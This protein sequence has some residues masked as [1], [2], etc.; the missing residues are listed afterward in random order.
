MPLR[1][2]SICAHPDDE[3]FAFGGALALYASRGV[4]TSVI[5]LTDGQA[6]KNRG[7]ASTGKELGQ[8]RRA[9]FEA[10]CKVLGVT[11]HQVLDYHD[12]QLEHERLSDLGGM[13]VSHIRRL[14]PHVVI[15]FGGEGGLNNHPDHTAVS[16]ATTAA[17]HW[18]ASPK[19]YITVGDLWKPQRLYYLTTNF[20][21]PDR[22]APLPTPW[23]HTL[24]ISSVFD[25]KKEAF[26]Q[27]KSQ[28][29]LMNFAVPIFEKRPKE[30]LYTLAY[31]VTPQPARQSTDLFEG[32]AET[33]N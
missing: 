29:P 3:C 13:L 22:E 10:S 4:E 18:S 20:F 2:L 11:N 12:G 9:E 16:V 6:A 33:G 26:A 32:V 14:R 25:K 30:E 17:F 1:L 21:L 28:A 24:D 23:T 5:C 19:R 8:I 27:H 31:A 7:D 15:T